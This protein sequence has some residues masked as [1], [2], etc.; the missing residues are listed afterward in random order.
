MNAD[1]K[2]ALLHYG[3]NLRFYLHPD[4]SR[5]LC[6]NKLSSMRFLLVDLDLFKSKGWNRIESLSAFAKLET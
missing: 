3:Y 6:G 1:A 4:F 5:D 2:L